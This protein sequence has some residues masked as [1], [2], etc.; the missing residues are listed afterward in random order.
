MC[1][2]FSQN[3]L[4]ACVENLVGVDTRSFVSLLCYF[5]TL[6]AFRGACAA[7]RRDV[8]LLALRAKCMQESQEVDEGEGEREHDR[9]GNDQRELLKEYDCA[10]KEEDTAPECSH[11]T[12][13]NTHAHR[14]DRIMGSI[15]AEGD[16]GV[17]VMGCQMH[18]VI[19]REANDNDHGDGL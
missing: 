9:H 8:T 19:D 6:S 14:R 16:L 1:S 15:V 11:R 10:S 4:I 13:E 18:H 12:T 3:F 7:H 2:F 17:D 5:F